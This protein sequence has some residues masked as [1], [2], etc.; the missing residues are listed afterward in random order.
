MPNSALANST[1][2]SIKT[3]WTNG[4]SGKVVTTQT[5][6]KLAVS[7]VKTE[8]PDGE[9]KTALYKDN[10][11]L[12]EVSNKNSEP[13]SIFG[14]TDPLEAEIEALNNIGL[15]S[16]SGSVSNTGGNTTFE[17]QPP[18]RASNS[19]PIANLSIGDLIAGITI[20]AASATVKS[21]SIYNNTNGTIWV[22][23]G[24]TPIDATFENAYYPIRS[25]GNSEYNA[26]LGHWLGEI[27]L[28]GQTVTS[29][30][31]NVVRES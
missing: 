19:V 14:K 25:G 17:Y 12:I 8:Y 5:F 13:H 23:H 22:R 1:T 28:K 15:A 2:V 29:G 21:V 7:V 4:T 10:S 11:K 24:S 9:V 20:P 3:E 31:F 26:A 27:Q 30:W 18:P 6:N 16:S